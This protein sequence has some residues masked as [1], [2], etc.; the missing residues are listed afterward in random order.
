MQSVTTPLLNVLSICGLVHMNGM[1]RGGVTSHIK[2]NNVH[3][4]QSVTTPLLSVLLICGLVQ[5]N[6][7][8]TG[9]SLAILKK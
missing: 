9:E 8:D 1:D 3:L 2:K 4:M 7:M 5:M 6:G